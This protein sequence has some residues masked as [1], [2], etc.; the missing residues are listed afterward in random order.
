M[1]IFSK[2]NKYYVFI[3][4]PKN[5]GKY[6]RNKIHKNNRVIK[7][8]WGVVSGFDLAH[9]PYSK[10][11]AFINPNVEHHYYAYT[12]NPYDRIIS[13]YYYKNPTK[14]K[15]DFILFLTKVLPTLD[16]SDF[17][18]E[19]IHYYPQY[20]F[21][22]DEHSVKVKMI[23]LEEVENPKR[24]TIELPDECIRIINTVYN[25]DFELFNYQ[26]ILDPFM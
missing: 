11:N 16:F 6:I 9:I 8:Y 13:A 7:S 5:G 3:H 14:Q 10:R 1:I 25:K 18:S 21:V 12:R 2:D 20:L 26:R 23:K 15:P 4:I 19:F 22:C 17:D 24:Y